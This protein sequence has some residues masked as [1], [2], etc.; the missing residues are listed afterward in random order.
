MKTLANGKMTIGALAAVLLAGC[1]GTRDCGLVRPKH[2]A[3]PRRLARA[4]NM[5]K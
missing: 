1:V 3:Y 2:V 4:G 5:I